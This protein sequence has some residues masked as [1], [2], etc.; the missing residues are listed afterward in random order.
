MKIGKHDVHLHSIAVHFTNALYPVALF[1]LILSFFYQKDVS[2]LTYFHLMILATVSVP[3]S[4][5]TGFIEW[6][7][8]YRGAKVRIF[9]RKQRSG[10]V[11]LGLGITCTLWYG[12]DPAVLENGGGLRI[13]FLSLHFAILPNVI[14][15][16]YLGGKLVFGSAH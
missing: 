9:T 12:W 16:G 10:L 2:L 6:K 11:L 13:V 15:L 3:I 7:Q 4:Y 5:I 14:Y 1:F 8:K